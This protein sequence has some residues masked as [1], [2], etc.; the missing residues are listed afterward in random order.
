MPSVILH[1]GTTISEGAAVEID[2][3]PI[4]LQAYLN[5]AGTSATCNVYG[6]LTTDAP[7]KLLWT[8]GLAGASDT[9]TYVLDEKWQFLKA[10][11]SAVSSATATIVM[12]E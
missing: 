7:W 5:A 4:T 6:K 12:M 3:P 2:S 8:A 9:A 10:D 1:S 11:I